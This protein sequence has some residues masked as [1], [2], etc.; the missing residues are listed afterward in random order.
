MAKSLDQEFREMD[1]LSEARH[2]QESSFMQG[3]R[4]GL[5]AAAKVCEEMAM[6]HRVAKDI[7]LDQSMRDY[8]LL[9]AIGQEDA[10]KRIRALS[11]TPAPPPAGSP[12]QR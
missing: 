4:A 7:S 3:Y 2:F 10:A 5:E 12:E 9:K 8:E 1:E 11:D 6:D